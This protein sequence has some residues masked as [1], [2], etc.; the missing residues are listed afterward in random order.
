MTSTELLNA[1]AQ[2][3][4]A[5]IFGIVAISSPGAIVRCPLFCSTRS[6]SPSLLIPEDF[7]NSV[8]YMACVSFWEDMC[9][10]A[11]ITDLTSASLLDHCSKWSFS[12]CDW[13]HIH[14][15]RCSAFLSGD[16]EHWECSTILCFS[17]SCA[18]ILSFAPFILPCPPALSITR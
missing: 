16:L 15:L 17:Y 1:V 14:M 4:R 13:R 7:G 3:L 2:H 11:L 8:E 6:I 10:Q 5:S 18:Q 12:V 9:S